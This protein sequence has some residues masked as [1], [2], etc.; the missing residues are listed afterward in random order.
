VRASPYTLVTPPGQQR[1]DCQGCGLCCRGSL[2]VPLTADE[3][4]HLCAQGWET[5]LGGPV[6][7]AEPAGLRLAHAPDGAC[8]FLTPE[9]RCR[10]HTRHGEAA[11]PLACRLYPFR[12]L[13]LGSQVRVDVRFDCP[14]VARNFG[15]PLPSHR[16]SLLALL[17]QL[18]PP[19]AAALPPPPLFPGVALPWGG[20]CRVAETC[21]GMLGET[22][23]SLTR[24]IIAIRMLSALIRT[25]R[26]L[27]L[28]GRK[29]SD[30]LGTVRGKVDD[31]LAAAPLPRQPLG[32]LTGM[33]F[34]QLLNLYLKRD[35]R[36]TLPSLRER[37][38]TGLRF[39]WG[40]GALPS[41]RPEWAGVTFAALEGA[42]GPLADAVE[43]PVRRYFRHRLN[44][45][46]FCGPTY[47]G[48]AFLD[49]LDAL[50]L[51]YP[52]TLW[53]ARANACGAGRTALTAA[54]I[55]EALQCIDHQHGTN[56][57][58]HLPSERARQRLLTDRSTLRALAIWYGT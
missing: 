27:E 58:L 46:A 43:A 9:G 42:W 20:L 14:A 24:Q 7:V 41:A 50:C 4:A 55:E 49:G 16:A 26:L 30:F 5:E 18:L 10:I 28:E 6:A 54:D 48:R 35:S 19:G 22:G 29:L 31:G 56:P 39:V 44:S 47:Y 53:V 40:G 57:L 33:L 12:L 11:K 52:L 3:H 23:M 45:L 13:P 38:T 21:D 2:T 1:F 36:G 17:P 37:L 51:T 34:R 25:P 8:V 15:R 32:H